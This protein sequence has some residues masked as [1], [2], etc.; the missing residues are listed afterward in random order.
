MRPDKG[1]RMVVLD[2]RDY[3]AK[4]ENS[5]SD[6]TNFN[7]LGKDPA[8]SREN[9]LTILLRQMRNEE[10]LTKQEYQFIRPTLLFGP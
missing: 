7:L 3:V 4:L 8:I 5:L 9:A 1:R 6:K 10:Y 2:C